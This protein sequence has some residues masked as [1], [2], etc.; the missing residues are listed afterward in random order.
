MDK[1]HRHEHATSSWLQ[2]HSA[3]GLFIGLRLA[4]RFIICHGQAPS[5][6]APK[7]TE[8]FFAFS[9]ESFEYLADDSCNLLTPQG[10][11]AVHSKARSAMTKSGR[12]HQTSEPLGTLLLGLKRICIL[13]TLVPDPSAFQWASHPCSPTTQNFLRFRTRP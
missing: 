3:I 10:T 2:C 9:K 6:H 1:Y 8:I 12:S 11:T 4:R 13:C 5:T 7:G